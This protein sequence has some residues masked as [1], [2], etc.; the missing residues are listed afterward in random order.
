MALLATPET[1]AP[2][3]ITVDGFGAVAIATGSRGRGTTAV[4]G[5]STVLSIISL[6]S[7]STFPAASITAAAAAGSVAGV[8]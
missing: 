3:E 7:A 4:V 8:H 1:P 5:A 2:G 6:S